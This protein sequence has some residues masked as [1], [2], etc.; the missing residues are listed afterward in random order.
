MAEQ[1]ETSFYGRGLLRRPVLL[2]LAAA[3]LAG[4]RLAMAQE[5]PRA[6]DPRL[7]KAFAL[8]VRAATV[9]SV[10]DRLSTAMGVR[11]DT[12][13]TIGYERV[14]LYAPRAT[15]G[16]LQEALGALYQSTWS[17]SGSGED[18]RYRLGSND[19]LLARAE[20]LRTQ[21]RSEFVAQLLQLER[22]VTRR[23]AAATAARLKAAVQERRPDLPQ[24][25]VDQITAGYVDQAQLLEPLRPNLSPVLQRT[26]FTW[27]PLN[28]LSG[29]AQRL[30]TAFYL[31]QGGATE[32]ADTNRA[33]P[34]FALDP[35]ALYWPRA[36]IEYRLLYGDRW[37]GDILLARVGTSDSW[38]NAVLSSALFP[39]PDYGSLY[40][41]V[42]KRP[43][44]AASYKQ[45]NIKI[46]PTIQSWDQAL[47]AI[48]QGANINVLSDVYL[49]PDVFRPADPKRVLSGA[50]LS[51]LLDHVAD[52]YGCIWWKAGD[53]YVFRNRM[54][55]EE[56][57]VAVPDRL[58]QTMGSNLASDQQLS[59]EALNGLSALTDEQ[60]LTL[61]L[62]GSAAGNAEAPQG[63]FDF[64]EVSLAHAGLLMISQMT[65]AQR[66]QARGSGLPFA[67]MTPV[68]QYLFTSLAYDRGIASVPATQMGW[69]FAFRDA[70]ER[71]KVGAGW[72]EVGQIMLDFNCGLNGVRQAR[73]AARAPAYER[74]R[75][76]EE[77]Q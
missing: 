65:D 34:A 37:A 52:Y 14:T 39:L 63:S 25:S 4:A 36:R 70:F 38:A 69:S 76:A 56:R 55:A 73:L 32:P 26:G 74:P 18:T 5:A 20:Q 19:A 17:A 29:P 51:Q 41:D 1:V 54:W 58:L 6:A 60:L 21:R 8:E 50:T 9:G 57:R 15:V 59:A 31:A 46:D 27:L 2:L 11:L 72:A 64:E 68:Q 16:G 61:H 71:R 13:R 42:A 10:L 45:V 53:F 47:A 77:P 24:A 75:T 7:E 30:A 66:V 3:A 62:Y 12:D 40:S 22:D 67:L 43:T 33:L 28:R 23:G 44:D 35:G 48:S 49:R